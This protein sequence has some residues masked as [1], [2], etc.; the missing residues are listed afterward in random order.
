MDA[1]QPGGSVDQSDAGSTGPHGLAAMARDDPGRVADGAGPCQQLGQ[2]GQVGGPSHRPVRGRRSVEALLAQL[3]HR[4]QCR[5]RRVVEALRAPPRDADRGHHDT[6]RRLERE[7]GHRLDPGVEEV[8]RHPGGCG[9][10]PLVRV[11]DECD[12]AGGHRAGHRSLRP[13]RV[14]GVLLCQLAGGPG[15]MLDPDLAGGAVDGAERRSLG[16]EDEWYVSADHLC[17]LFRGRGTG[18]ML[19][20]VGGAADQGVGPGDG[21]LVARAAQRQDQ[22]RAGDHAGDAEQEPGQL[23]VGGPVVLDQDRHGPSSHRERSPDAAVGWRIAGRQCQGAVID[24]IA[25]ALGQVLL[26]ALCELGAVVGAGDE[27]DVGVPALLDGVGRGADPVQR[28]DDE[29]HPRPAGQG[30]GLGR[31]AAAAVARLG[32]CLD[33]VGIGRHVEADQGVRSRA[34]RADQLHRPVAVALGGRCDR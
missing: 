27:A 6:V 18:Q 5:H 9:G 7:V 34:E 33:R 4:L 32:R 1:Q 21:P 28:L 25:D 26:D 17:N 14:A 13:E 2:L 22:D 30:D 15:T 8:P 10:P 16:V 23:M 20:E 3:G 31:R 29:E 24:L 19:G 12:L 11:V